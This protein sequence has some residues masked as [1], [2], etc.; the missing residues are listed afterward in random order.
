MSPYKRTCIRRLKISIK[1]SF[2]RRMFNAYTSLQSV[3]RYIVVH[4][5]STRYSILSLWTDCAI[6]TFLR[7]RASIARISYGNSVRPS[8]CPSVT[9]RYR[10][11]P[12]WDREFWFLPCDSLDYLVFRDKIWC[13]WVKGIPTKEGHPSKKDVILPVL[14]RLAWKWLQIGT[15]MLLNITST[16]DELLRSV[17]IDD[18]HLPWT[19]K[20][21]GDFWLQKSELRQ[22]GWK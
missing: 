15:D 21:I 16:G 22:N 11:K 12:R 6:K 20:I 14:A 17:N 2:P 5:T 4:H 8:V 13:R 1:D 9:T 10:Y 19:L 3:R 7:A 18:L